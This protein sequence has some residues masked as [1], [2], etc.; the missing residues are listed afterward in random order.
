MQ[1]YKFVP[2]ERVLYKFN[3]DF[4]NRGISET[5]VIDWIIEALEEVKLPGVSQE[6]VRFIEVKDHIA[7]LPEHYHQVIQIARNT[8]HDTLEPCVE[9]FVE[10]ETQEIEK[11]TQ[12]DCLDC[13]NQ[14]SKNMVPVDSDGRIIGDYEVAYYR[15][16]FD[17]QWE[18]GAFTG[19]HYYQ[20]EWV[21]VSLANHSFFSSVVCQEKNFQSIYQSCEDEYTIEGNN[22]KFSFKEGVIALSYRRQA[23]SQETGMPLIPEHKNLIQAITYFIIF[24]INERDCWDRI[25]GAC[26][27]ADRAEIKYETQLGRF[28]NN[29]KMFSSNDEYESSRKQL[30]YLLPNNRSYDAFFGNLGRQETKLF[31]DP[32][33]RRQRYRYNINR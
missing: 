9:N 7:E 32:D 4:K 27:L 30:S 18:Y 33:K 28:K 29:N 1:K 31:R 13:D 22:L 10:E 23:V 14:W 12:E 26:Q 17:L 3:R 20:K 11:E 8:R 6:A 15:P 5:E 25:Q 2:I 21:P 19:S 24:K 16:F